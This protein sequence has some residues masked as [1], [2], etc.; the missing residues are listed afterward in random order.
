MGDPPS[1]DVL[2]TVSFE[3]K[4]IGQFSLIGCHKVKRGWVV[5]TFARLYAVAF[6]ER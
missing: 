4:R 6:R 5:G 3:G 1:T 2:V